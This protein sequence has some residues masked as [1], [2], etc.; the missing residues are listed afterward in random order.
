MNEEE[1]EE[2]SLGEKISLKFRKKFFV[3]KAI[4]IM[5]IAILVAAYVAL[6]LML[7]DID[8]PQFDVTEYK[9]YTLSDA[10]KKAIANIGDKEIKIYTYGYAEDSQFIKF[11]K[12]YNEVNKAITYEVINDESGKDLVTK[13]GLDSGNVVVIM[14]SGD[15]EKIIDSSE[16]SSYDYTTYQAIDITEQTL[17]NSIL[18]LAEENKP[19]VYFVEGHDEVESDL[20]GVL[21]GFL[22]NEAFNVNTLNIL[23]T[24]KIPDDCSVLAIMSPRKDLLESEVPAI[25]DYINRGGNIYFSQDLLEQGTTFP[26]FQSIL[27]EY[28]VSVENG[29]I[30]ENSTDYSTN[31]PFVFYPTVSNSHKITEDIAL[32]GQNM[33]LVDSGRLNFKTDDELKALG[34]EKNVLLTSS[35][36]SSFVTDLTADLETAQKTAQVGSSNIAAVLTKKINPTSEEDKEAEEDSITSELVIIANGTYIEDVTY[37]ALDSQYPMSYMGSNKDFALNSFSYL[38]QK[39]NILTIRKDMSSSTYTPTVVQ[40]RIVI[41]IITLVPILIIVIG[42]LVWRRR[43]KM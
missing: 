23:S 31:I 14:Q 5:I 41:A 11:L 10:S 21:K 35:D 3:S 17:T 8:L 6:N 7:T 32:M 37:S 36:E 15:S 28:G 34:V 18:A 16:F 43:R 42:L 12:Q 19:T 30:M 39:E 40:N 25:K 27:D 20:L 13:Y 24:G 9:V 29:Y 38:G 22:Q 1:K 2:A 33:L 26:N 4:T